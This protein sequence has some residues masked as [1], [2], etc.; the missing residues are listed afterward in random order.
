MERNRTKK[1]NKATE[2][3]GDVVLRAGKNSLLT[4]KKEFKRGTRP[5]ET[6]KTRVGRRMSAGTEAKVIFYVSRNRRLRQKKK[7]RTTEK[8]KKRTVEENAEESWEREGSRGL[9]R[10]REGKSEGESAVGRGRLLT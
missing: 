8:E 10:E 4:G 1:N 9:D 5:G 7:E 3:G 6:D 2:K